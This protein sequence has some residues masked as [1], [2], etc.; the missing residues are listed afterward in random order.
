M[1]KW[2]HQGND[3]IHNCYDMKRKIKAHFIPHDYTTIILYKFE[4]C[5]QG[6]KF[7]RAYIS[8][9]QD[10]YSRTN[11]SKNNYLLILSFVGELCDEIKEQIPLQSV[12]HCDFLD[13]IKI[14]LWVEMQI[15]RERSQ[16]SKKLSQPHPWH[17]FEIPSFIRSQQ[18][19][20][21]SQQLKVK[22]V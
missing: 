11:F 5:L 19:N 2:V 12:I 17:Q 18:P 10:Y 9:F 15:Q 1:A 14:T 16:A 6:T 13:V 20:I 7:V 8:Q 21:K 4:N 3:K 22:Y